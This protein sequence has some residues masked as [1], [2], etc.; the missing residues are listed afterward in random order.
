[1]CNELINSILLNNY[2]ESVEHQIEVTAKLVD[3]TAWHKDLLN[4]RLVVEA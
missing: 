4:N 1:M 3:F 2:F